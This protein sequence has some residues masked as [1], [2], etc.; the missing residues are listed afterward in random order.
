M[1]MTR[2]ESVGLPTALRPR[3]PAMLPKAP[4]LIRNRPAK[5][6][7]NQVLSQ[8]IA[9]FND[10][11]RIVAKGDSFEAARAAGEP[12]PIVEPA[13]LPYRLA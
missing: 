3:R 10:G 4:N 8:W 11:E 13:P 6:V 7:K 5:R 1:N 9:W 2:P 12:D